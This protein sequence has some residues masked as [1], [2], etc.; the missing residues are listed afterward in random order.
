MKKCLKI[1]TIMGLLLGISSCGKNGNFTPHDYL[2]TAV[3]TSTGAQVMPLNTRVMIRMF[4][5]SEDIRDDIYALFAN[6]IQRSHRLFD[7]HYYYVEEDKP[8]VNLRSINESYGSGNSVL[9]DQDL[10]DLLYLSIEISEQTL[11]YFNPTMGDLLDVWQY[12]EEGEERYNAYGGAFD[13]PDYA[14]VAAAQACVV[15]Y[16]ELRSILE[17]DESNNSVTFHPYKACSSVKLSLGAI[18]KG[19]ALDLAKEK[20]KHAFPNTPL[21][22]DAGSSSIVTIG[23][24]PTPTSTN[25]P[26]KYRGKWLVGMIS[27]NVPYLALDRGQYVVATLAFSGDKTFSTSGDFERY[28]Y[29]RNSTPAGLKRNH[30]LNPHTGYSE[31]YWRMLSLF[32][33]GKSAILDG[34]STALINLPDTTQIMTMLTNINTHFQMNC[35]VFIEEEGVADKVTL[36]ASA[37]FANHID[38]TTIKSSLVTSIDIALLD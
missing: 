13:D 19:F 31:I 26:K 38:T 5:D 20:L 12:D 27:A 25:R 9:I 37:Y 7:R 2:V 11:G 17:L 15:P 10:F 6:S 4:E 29:A 1:M 28:Y 14:D 16:Q 22:L 8:V 21:I 32:G 24:N 35:G 30:I 23:I 34:L 33:D 3:K 18:A 36:L